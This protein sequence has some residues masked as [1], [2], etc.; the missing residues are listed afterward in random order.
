MDKKELNLE[1]MSRVSG[2]GFDFIDLMEAEANCKQCGCTMRTSDF[3]A[4]KGY[5]QACREK[6]QNASPLGVR[7]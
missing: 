6:L 5:C 4:G 3:L 2:G 1:D 7:L